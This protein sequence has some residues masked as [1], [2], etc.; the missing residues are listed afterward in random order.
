MAQVRRGCAGRE[1]TLGQGILPRHRGNPNGRDNRERG[2]SMKLHVSQV[3]LDYD[4]AFKAGLRDSYDW[5]QKV[6]RAFPN[7]DGARRDFLTRLDPLDRRMRL[8]VLSETP[9]MRPDWCPK[10]AWETK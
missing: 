2:A 6:W 7:R 1:V 10:P 9:P 3:L 4:T 5:H 8:F